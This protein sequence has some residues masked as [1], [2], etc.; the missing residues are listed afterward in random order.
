VCPSLGF[1]SLLIIILC[2]Y[3][4][5][6]QGLDSVGVTMAFR[7]PRAGYEAFASV[8]RIALPWSSRCWRLEHPGVI[9]LSKSP[10]RNYLSAR[11]VNWVMVRN[12]PNMGRKTSRYACLFNSKH[13]LSWTSFSVL[14]ERCLRVFCGA[15]PSITLTESGGDRHLSS[16]S[17]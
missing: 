4:Q 12:D 10:E 16:P 2:A 9:L 5:G 15:I 17:I 11:C 13:Y 3:G 1:V 14:A 7:G 8:S 6:L